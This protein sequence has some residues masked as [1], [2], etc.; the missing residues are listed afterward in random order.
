MLQQRRSMMSVGALA[1]AL[2]GLLFPRLASAQFDTATVLGTVV[3]ATGAVVPG[4]TVTLQERRY[5]NRVDH[6][7][8][9]RGQL[10]VPER[11]HRH[12]HA[13]APNCRASPRPWPKN[14]EGH[15]QRPPARDLALQ[16]GG[17]RRDRAGRHRGR[18]A[19]RDRL[20][21]PRPGH[22]P[23]AD[24]QPAAQR[25]RLRR[26]GA[27]QPGRAQVVASATSRDA[28][29]NVNGLRSSLNNFMLDGVDNNSY[30]TSN[31]GFSNQVVQV[32]ARRG[33]GVQGRRPTTSAPS[34]AAPAAP[35]STRRSAAAPTSSTARPGSSS[36]TRR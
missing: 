2:V 3:D 27:A 7:H 22:R 8:R 13:C 21:R 29:F 1:L 34:T 26:S 4:A 16:V 32:V 23:R 25:P 14:V 6:C 20:E 19:A 18:D 30:G 15:G 11:P 10:S 35:S 5:R 12:L 9:H 24:R 31:Q 28:S 17:H 33:R 36:A